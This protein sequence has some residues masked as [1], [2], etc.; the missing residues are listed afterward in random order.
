MNIGFFLQSHA[1]F[2]GTEKIL[3][4]TIVNWKNKDDKLFFFCNNDH[5]GFKGIKR[6]ISKHAKL[7]TYSSNIFSPKSSEFKSSILLLIKKLFYYVFISYISMIFE[8]FIFKKLF[9][10]FDLDAIFIHNGGWPAARMTRS[11]LL[12]SHSLKVKKINLVIHGI[13]KPHPFSIKFQ[14]KMIMNLISKIDMRVITV[15]KAAA[16]SIKKN[17]SLPIPKVIYNGAKCEIKN[18][19]LRS[20][21]KIKENMFVV[22]S[23]GSLDVNRGHHILIESF[24]QIIKQKKNIILII[25]GDGSIKDR[26]SIKSLVKKFHLN[27]N[28]KLLGYREDIS[29]LIYICNLLVNP[30]ISTESFGLTL[31]EAMSLKKPTIASRI[32]GTTEIVEN[33]KT[34]FLVKANNA[35]VLSSK[36]LKISN[37]PKTRRIFGE[38]GFKKYKSFFTLNNMIFN[39][40]KLLN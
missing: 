33:N 23:V 39:Y 14:E 6:K 8:F 19:N 22:L 1:Q 13:A 40:K 26:R 2:G 21:I 15:S 7:V 38:N 28:V 30:V 29:D 12:A 17:T 3:T 18:K 35:E 37:D 31:I 36:I 20:Q 34:G 4:D 27:D 10:K 5:K 24:S 11:A 32:G 9:S 25:A 16:K